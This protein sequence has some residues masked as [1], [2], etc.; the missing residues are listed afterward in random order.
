MLLA[1]MDNTILSHNALKEISTTDDILVMALEQACLGSLDP[2]RECL[3]INKKRSQN[4]V[5][6]ETRDKVV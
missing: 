4:A 1:V 6:E 2:Q 5:F 3:K